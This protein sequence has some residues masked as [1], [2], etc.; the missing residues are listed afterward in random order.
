MDALLI[1]I[2]LNS[3]DWLAMELASDA[4]CSVFPVNC[5]HKNKA[6]FNT[7]EYRINH[8]GIRDTYYTRKMGSY[9]LECNDIK[10]DMKFL[11]NNA[12]KRS[13]NP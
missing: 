2:S 7:T 6:C 5:T 12:V 9:T 4:C 1:K 8:L 10:K 13:N 11:S 3:K